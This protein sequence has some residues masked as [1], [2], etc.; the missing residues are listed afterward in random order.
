MLIRE[1]NGVEVVMGKL[2]L[3]SFWVIEREELILS[4]CLLV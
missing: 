3:W 4:V 1:K 2:V